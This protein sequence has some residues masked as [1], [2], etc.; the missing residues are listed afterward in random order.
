MKSKQKY[1]IQD[2]IQLCSVTPSKLDLIIT[3]RH[4]HYHKQLQMTQAKA[5]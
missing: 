5:S 4:W 3:L 2:P 1:Q